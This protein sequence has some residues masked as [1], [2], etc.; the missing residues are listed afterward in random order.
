MYRRNNLEGSEKSSLAK[1]E[2]EVQSGIILV[3]DDV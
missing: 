1:D 3:E 2:G